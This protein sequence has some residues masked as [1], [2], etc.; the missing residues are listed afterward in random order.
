MNYKS[1][2]EKMISNMLDVDDYDLELLA[3]WAR[4]N[5]LPEPVRITRDTFRAKLQQA[6]VAPFSIT[7]RLFE[8]WTNVAIDFQQEVQEHLQEIW[9]ACFA[10]NNPPPQ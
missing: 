7:P 3:K 10:E 2:L 8:K 4:R 9:E 5:D 6:L 1:A